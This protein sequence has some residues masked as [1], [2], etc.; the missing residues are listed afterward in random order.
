MCLS[1]KHIFIVSPNDYFF[2][3]HLDS[4]V[5][6]A[7]LNVRDFVVIFISSEINLDI[8]NEFPGLKCISYKNVKVEDFIEAKTITSMSLNINNANYVSKIIKA[9]PDILSKYFVYLT[10]D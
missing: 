10:D 4:M 8:V 2:N 9:S 1:E 6:Q 7:G 3:L 5:N